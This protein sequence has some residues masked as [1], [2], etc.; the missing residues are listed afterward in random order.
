MFVLVNQ[1]LIGQTIDSVQVK[2][3]YGA[4]DPDLKFYMMANKIDLY[5]IKIA[6]STSRPVKFTIV[7]KEIWDG[8]ITKVDT[9]MSAK[10]FNKLSL[11]T[12]DSLNL[13]VLTS[14]ITSD[15]IR[16]NFDFN[17]AG[18]TYVKFSKSKS[19][20][21]SLR[22]GVLSNGRQ[23][24]LSSNGVYPLLVYS[25]PYE[26]PKYPGYLFYCKLTGEN[27]SPLDWYEKYGIK[28]Y[29]IFDLITE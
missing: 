1:I 12:G 2:L 25:L 20:S 8:N 3:K 4:D 15:S 21:Y 19:E 24:K 26:D 27:I 18:S 16:F 7:S 5:K 23:I 13:S 22:D 11:N 10:Y 14:H 6:N 17:R 29:I 28:H 9:L